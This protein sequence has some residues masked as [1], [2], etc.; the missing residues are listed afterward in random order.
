MILLS[1][2]RANGYMIE[3]QRIEM[4]IGKKMRKEMLLTVV[5]SIIRGSIEAEGSPVDRDT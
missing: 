1:I 2:F 3:I 4:G 5:T